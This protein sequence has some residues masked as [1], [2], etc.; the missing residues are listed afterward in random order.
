MVAL[1]VPNGNTMSRGQID[2]Y[3]KFVSKLGAKGLAYIKIIDVKAFVNFI[4]SISCVILLV[5]SK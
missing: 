4:R 1:K 2:D 5:T 3:T